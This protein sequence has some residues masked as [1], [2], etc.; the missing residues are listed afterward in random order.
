MS[1]QVEQR[2]RVPE[3]PWS[4]SG[5]ERK[6]GERGAQQA[7]V[8]EEA[9]PLRPSLGR[10]GKGPE[11]MEKDRGGNQKRRDHQ[12]ADVGPDA[13]HHRED[14]E[15]EPGTDGPAGDIRNRDPPPGRGHKARVVGDVT[16]GRND[17][18]GDEKDSPDEKDRAGSGAYVSDRLP[19]QSGGPGRHRAWCRAH[20][21]SA[22]W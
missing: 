8:A 21:S 6:K 12:G 15:D 20:D 11:G 18:E 1:T 13:Q 22:R 16:L 7:D 17:E 19:R 4:D 2:A 14:A 3:S 5:Q 10:V 9:A